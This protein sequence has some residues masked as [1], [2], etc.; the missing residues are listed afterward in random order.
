MVNIQNVTDAPAAQLLTAQDSVVVL[1]DHQPQMFFGT[2]SAD[3]G[4]IINATV[5][6]AKS[7]KVFDVP[8]VLTTVASKSFSGPL[9]APLAEQFPGTEPI[10]RTTMNC[11][12]D[13]R[14]VDAVKATGRPKIVLAGL[15][16]EVCISFAALSATDQGY[17]VYVPTDAC[18]G[19]SPVAHNNAVTRMTQRGIV[20]TTWLT[21]LLEW[22]RDWG[23][24]DTY[25]PV[26]DIVTQHAGAYGIGVTYARAMFGSHTG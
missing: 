26:M 21:T 1:V 14:V 23:R 12:E 4:D 9:L 24:T 16:T 8:V 6:L 20:P 19:V 11:W 2:T 3:R 15:W 22:Q 5:A 17:Q 7:A 13:Q 10:D 25:E 18:G